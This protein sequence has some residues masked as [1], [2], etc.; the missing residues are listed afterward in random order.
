MDFETTFTDAL[1]RTIADGVL[2]V[3]VHT[4]SYWLRTLLASEL[5]SVRQDIWD[6]D[7]RTLFQELLALEEADEIAVTESEL[8]SRFEMLCR[9]EDLRR[10]GV[11]AHFDGRLS[12]DPLPG[13]ELSDD[14]VRAARALSEGRWHR[15]PPERATVAIQVRGA[16]GH[17]TVNALQ[18]R[19][20]MVSALTRI[21]AVFETPQAIASAIG[22]RPARIQDW[23]AGHGAPPDEADLVR[24][25]AIV[26]GE[27]ED[28]ILPRGIRDWL[29][30]PQYGLSNET[31]IAALKGGRVGDVL[32][33][34]N[35]AIHFA[36]Y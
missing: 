4:T 22:I 25:V 17:W 7:R 8:R 11:V 3:G 14:A 2:E 9:V 10:L 29:I 33:E 34:A 5:R 26:I 19:L 15:D 24:R 36:Y 18:H 28:A 30:S 21:Y 16:I 1:R 23:L 6:A 12:V 20:H 35:A 32:A 13:L 31:P 27:M